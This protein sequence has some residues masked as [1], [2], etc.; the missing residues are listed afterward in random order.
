MKNF[1]VVLSDD[2][3]RQLCLEFLACSFDI[4]SL[5]RS[6]ANGRVSFKSFKK[7]LKSLIEIQHDRLSKL[8]DLVLGGSE[9]EN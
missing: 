3:Y 8:Y 1:S 4:E 7:E 6:Y 9:D 5:R 2:K